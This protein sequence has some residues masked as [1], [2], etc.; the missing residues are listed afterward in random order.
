[1]KLI[2]YKRNGNGEL[3]EIGEQ[4]INIV[5][6]SHVYEGNMNYVHAMSSGGSIFV[7]KNEDIQSFRNGKSEIT[8]YHVVMK[9]NYV[10]RDNVSLNHTLLSHANGLFVDEVKRILEQYRNDE[11]SIITAVNLGQFFTYD[12]GVEGIDYTKVTN[13]QE[14][15]G[16]MQL[17]FLSEDIREPFTFELNDVISVEDVLQEINALEVAED[18]VCIHHED[19]LLY[20]SRNMEKLKEISGFIYKII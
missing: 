16:E 15:F 20:A 10:G 3:E 4:H 19:G 17:T 11:Y 8:I 12:A 6:P 7:I 13:N 18:I 9:E 14:D 1:M 2:E 5:R